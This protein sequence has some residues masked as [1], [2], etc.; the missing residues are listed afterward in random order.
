MLRNGTDIFTLAK[1]MDTKDLCAA[2]V[3]EANYPDTKRRITGLVL[4]IR[5]EMELFDR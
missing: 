5:C 1:L 4:W 2:A 3:S